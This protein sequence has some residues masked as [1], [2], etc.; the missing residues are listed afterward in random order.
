M[1]VMTLAPI[2]HLSSILN[3]SVGIIEK[4]GTFWLI[5]GT[6]FKAC[7]FDNIKLQYNNTPLYISIL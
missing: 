3:D 5:G 4:E 2:Y 7:M 6:L 1:R